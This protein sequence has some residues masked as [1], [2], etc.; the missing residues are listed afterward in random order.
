MQATLTRKSQFPVFVLALA[1][2]GALILGGMGGYLFKSLAAHPAPTVSGAGTMARSAGPTS[3][4]P[5]VDPITGYVSGS[6]DDYRILDLLKRS[7]YEGGAT[8]VPSGSLGSD[9]P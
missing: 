2:L 6:A 8:V 7:G 4:R 1:L 9:R 3:A 5:A